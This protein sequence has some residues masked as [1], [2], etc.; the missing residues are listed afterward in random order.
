MFPHMLGTP[1]VSDRVRMIEQA[2]N[3]VNT[4][5]YSKH[6][7]DPSEHVESWERNKETN[8]LTRQEE[9]TYNSALAFLT[10]EFNLGPSDMASMKMVE[11][12]GPHYEDDERDAEDQEESPILEEK[13]PF[14]QV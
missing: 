14:P 13:S 6:G 5:R 2:V 9:S 4:F 3:L 10:K 12:P 8:P 1:V 7:P 11:I